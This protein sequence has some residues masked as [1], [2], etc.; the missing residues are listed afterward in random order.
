MNP[1]IKPG[2]SYVAF[3]FMALIYPRTLHPTSPQTWTLF[4]ELNY[5]VGRCRTC[6]Q[7]PLKKGRSGAVNS[8]AAGTGGGWWGGGWWVMEGNSF[9]GLEMH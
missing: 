4:L 9:Q 2:I 1:D 6:M 7:D 8:A 5:R 3:C